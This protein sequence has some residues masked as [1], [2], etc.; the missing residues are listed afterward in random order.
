MVVVL[1]CAGVAAVGSLIPADAADNQGM[2]LL[3]CRLMLANA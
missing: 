3:L 1:Q 2:P